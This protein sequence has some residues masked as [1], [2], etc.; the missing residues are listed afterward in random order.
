MYKCKDCG[1]Q[2]LGSQRRDKSQ[3]ITDY[4]EGK[5]TREQLAVK[6]GVSSKTIALDSFGDDPVHDD[7]KRGFQL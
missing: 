3:V 5:Q 6:Y 1:K 7:P 2:F 4:V